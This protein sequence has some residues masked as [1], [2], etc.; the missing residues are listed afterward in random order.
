MLFFDLNFQREIGQTPELMENL[1]KIVIC[2]YTQLAFPKLIIILR[3]EQ[4]SVL[5]TDYARMMLLFPDILTY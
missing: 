5:K 4:L 2:L 3:K 1:Q